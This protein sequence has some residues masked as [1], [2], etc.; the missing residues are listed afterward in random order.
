MPED[1]PPEA[2]TLVAESRLSLRLPLVIR[3]DYRL[4]GTF[5]CFNQ[6]S[7]GYRQPLAPRFESDKTLDRTLRMNSRQRIDGMMADRA[8]FPVGINDRGVAVLGKYHG[9]LVCEHADGRFYELALAGGGRHR[10][11][12]AHQDHGA[13]IEEKGLL[14]L[15][16]RIEQGAWLRLP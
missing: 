14:W 11:F 7:G 4:A 9:H 13:V 10:R 8:E 6:T 5:D 3:R 12:T 1:G 15:L 16:G 2:S